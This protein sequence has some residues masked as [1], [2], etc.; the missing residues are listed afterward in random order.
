MK[1]PLLLSNDKLRTKEQE[2]RK[3]LTYRLLDITR[4]DCVLRIYERARMNISE[5]GY[6]NYTDD[7]IE[8]A[9]TVV[10]KQKVSQK[11]SEDVLLA[12]TLQKL[13][14]I[15]KRNKKETPAKPATAIAESPTVIKLVEFSPE[16][17]K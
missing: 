7:M 5:N 4:P 13:R 15:M 6:K 17:L 10:L 3:E 1:T 11:Q 16:L 9:V 2:K 8:D 12:K 14:G